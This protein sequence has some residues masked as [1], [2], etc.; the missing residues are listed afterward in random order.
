MVSASR[1]GIDARVLAVLG[2]TNTGK[3]HLAVERL[4]GHKD[5]VIGLPLRLLAREIYDRIVRARGETAAALVTGEEKI[6]P[7]QARYFV[8]TVEAMPLDRGFAF[9]AVDEI[10]LAADPDRGHVFTERLLHARGT[11]ET[12]LLGSET[13]RGLIRRL[14]P[15]AEFVSRPRFSSLTYAGPKKLSR[16]PP[17]SAIVAFSAVDVY[18]IAELIRRHRGGAAVVLGALSPRTRNAQVAL[19]EDGDVDYMVATDAI[20]MGLNLNVNHVAFASLKKFDGFS[21]R[22][23]AA[24]E[25]AQIAGRAGRHMNSGTFGTTAEAGAFDPETVEAVE[26]HRFDPLRFL[27]WRNTRLEY[28]SVGALLRS[29]EEPAPGRVLMRAPTAEDEASLRALIEVPAIA[30]KATHPAA[31]RLLWEV[32]QIPDYRKT[33]EDSHVRMLGQIYEHLMAADGGRLPTDWLASQVDRLD[34]TDGDIDALATRIAHTRTWTYVSHRPDWVDDPVYWQERARAIEDRLSDA[35]HERLTQRFV[36]RRAAAISRKL[37]SAGEVIAAVAA[38]GEVLV[39]GHTV[40]RLNGLRFVADVAALGEDGRAFRTAAMKALPGPTAARALALI[41]EPDPAFNLNAQAQIEWRGIAVAKL[42]AGADALEPRVQLLPNDL[43]D[44][45]VRAQVVARLERWTRAHI[46]R[47]LAALARLDAAE[48]DGVARGLA[49]ELRRNLGFIERAAIADMAKTLGPDDRA[50]LKRLGVAIGRVATYLPALLKPKRRALLGQLAAVRDARAAAEPV[51]GRASFA[52]AGG[53]ED[54]LGFTRLGPR[55]VR[56]DLAERLA[57][58]LARAAAGPA[59]TVVNAHELMALA[60]CPRAEFAALAKALGFRATEAGDAWLVAPRG[61]TAGKAKRRVTP[62]APA[63][64]D[65]P[66]A[67]LARLKRPRGGVHR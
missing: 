41:A 4:L 2:P 44:A 23:L 25:V 13:A 19:F 14:V 8:C 6:V 52:A 45:E 32:C 22:P 15:G 26:N 7:A 18:S 63:N 33:L 9:V 39:E 35:L 29:L 42:A 56:I 66:F 61:R 1:P 30:A 5:G 46:G 48:L 62:P 57:D 40:G 64:P 47:E 65:S 27:Y 55:W 60:G 34:R 17:R 54:T 58:A 11:E 28:R 51:D 24:P 50:R 36:D 31:V 20:G 67:V 21:F 59:A 10:Q 43:L 16:L 3:T 12:M 49:Y 38:D 53:A 37:K